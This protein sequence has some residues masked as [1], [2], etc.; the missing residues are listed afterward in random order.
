M[1]AGVSG[2]NRA[3][4][5]PETGGPAVIFTPHL[6]PM[7][8][9]ILCT[10]Y[11]PLRDPPGSGSGPAGPPRP[12]SEEIEARVREI[13]EWYAAFYGDEPF[14]RVLPP[15]SVAST[16]RVRLSNFCDI[17]VHL[18]Q[19]GSTLIVMSAIDNMVKGAA[20]QA[21]QNMNILLG[22]DET[23]GLTAIPASF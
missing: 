11:I 3:A 17:S 1:A 21:I 13:R 5:P 19:D 7:N 8:R 20:G 18:D 16:G 4:L 15:G 14:I 10:I 9:G 2:E 6:A 22:F 23:A 12:P